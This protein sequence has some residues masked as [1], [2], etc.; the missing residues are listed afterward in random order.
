M[1]RA[2]HARLQPPMMDALHGNTSIVDCCRRACLLHM[3]EA[4]ATSLFNYL[5]SDRPMEHVRTI[6][7]DIHKEASPKKRV[8]T[9]NV[10]AELPCRNCSVGEAWSVGGLGLGNISCCRS[11]TSCTR[12]RRRRW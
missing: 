12:G 3:T 6:W 11:R 1:E 2:L 4:Q 5:Q 7:K 10:V 9:N 8:R